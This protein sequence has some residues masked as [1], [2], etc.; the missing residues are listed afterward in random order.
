[1][2]GS[3]SAGVVE[4]PLLTAGQPFPPGSSVKARS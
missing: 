1:M 3:N 2:F 4:L